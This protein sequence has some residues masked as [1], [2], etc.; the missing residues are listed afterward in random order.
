MLFEN[1]MH[2]SSISQTRILI[3]HQGS[4]VSPFGSVCELQEPLGY[5]MKR[6]PPITLNKRRLEALETFSEKPH[7]RKFPTD[8]YP[9]LKVRPYKGLPPLWFVVIWNSEQITLSRDEISISGIV[10]FIEFHHQSQHSNFQKN[11]FDVHIFD[12]MARRTSICLSISI[13]HPDQ[14]FSLIIC[15][16]VSVLKFQQSFSITSHH[17][18]PPT[19]L[20]G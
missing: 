17:Y 7:G 15:N 13:Y 3:N 19:N 20:I 11:R 5:P 12:L 14:L 18:I 8:H 4:R 2:Q 16:L 10:S 1:Y 6:M 9:A